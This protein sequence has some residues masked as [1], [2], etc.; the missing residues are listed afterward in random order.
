MPWDE[1]RDARDGGRALVAAPP[2]GLRPRRPARPCALDAERPR[3]FA[4]RSGGAGAPPP[5]PASSVCT[6]PTARFLGVGARRR[7]TGEAR[8]APSCGSSADFRPSRLSCARRWS[9]LGAFDGIH[10]A[11]AKILTH[12]GGARPRARRCRR[13]PAPSSRTRR[14]CC[15]P[16][17]RPRPSRP[18]RRTWPAS[19]AARA[20]RHPRH[21]VH[22]WSSP[23]SRRRPSSPTC[24]SGPLGAR[25][26]VVGFNHTFG[27]ERPRDRG[28]PAASSGRAHGFVTHVLPPLQVDGPDRVLE[29]DP[30]GA[31]RGRRDARRARVPRP[32]VRHQ[33]ARAA[34]RGPGAHARLS[35][36]QPAAGPSAAPG[37]RGLRVPR[38]L[39]RRGS[40]AGGGQHRLPPDLRGAPV[41]G[42]G[43]PARLLRRP[44]RP[45]RS[46]ST[47]SSGSGPR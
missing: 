8:T 37:R 21:P 9:A 29:R 32:S 38:A 34:R 35:H 23:G 12:H 42:R 30:R 1:L 25:E 27:R 19:R 44:L 43:L 41:L 13:W 10:L 17:A 4:P 14:S 16:S 3:A 7:A 40:A 15:T 46:R 36:R 47:S 22:R 2:A 28:A 26:V 6:A 18:S 5:S 45:H 24:S 31:A 33:R 20:R 39:G 11:H